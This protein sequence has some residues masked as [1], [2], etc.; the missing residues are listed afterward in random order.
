[1][2]N[3]HS[4]LPVDASTAA[5]RSWSSQKNS[6]AARGGER[7]TSRA[8]RA[9]LRQFPRDLPRRHVDRAQN[10]LV[11]RSGIRPR[12]AAPVRFSG[13]PLADALHEHVAVLERLHVVEPCLRAVGGGV[14]IRG[15]MCGWTDACAFGRRLLSRHQHRPSV[16]ADLARPRQVTDEWLP[17]QKFAVGAIEDVEEPVAAGLNEKLSRPSFPR[18]VDEHG[19]LLRVP[20]PHVV[21]RELKVPFQAAASR[22]ERD[23]GAR[24]QI[25]AE[26]LVAVVVGTWIAGRP[27]HQAERGIVDARHPRRAAG[28]FDA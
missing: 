21:R 25:V 26:P 5:N 10:L 28:L 22:V 7:S 19:R 3:C 27:V 24:I 18:R 15:A 12:G 8:A 6:S 2:P 1:M 11:R 20:V 17:E 13:D 23:D 14:P 16:S 9:G 4:A